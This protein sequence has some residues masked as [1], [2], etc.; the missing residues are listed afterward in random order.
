M[1]RPD[2]DI[3]ELAPQ[4]LDILNLQLAEHTR[5]NETPLLS[6]LKDSLAT[7]N[8]L[9]PT[10]TLL[11]GTSIENIESIATYGVMSGELFD[12]NE[13]RETNYCADFFRLQ[14]DISV[15]D[16][17]KLISG[18]EPSTGR[19]YRERMEKNI[20]LIKGVVGVG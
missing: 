7:G 16:Y 4:P 9:L 18:T 14:E 17:T 5:L 8:T 1:W 2:P 3:K 12:K 13:D 19:I 10:G 11:H 20:C 15:G 6:E